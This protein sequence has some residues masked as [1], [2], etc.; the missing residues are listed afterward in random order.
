MVFST[1]LLSWYSPTALHLAAEAHEIPARRSEV[2]SF[3]SG[4]V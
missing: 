1:P 3:L 2:E 4:V